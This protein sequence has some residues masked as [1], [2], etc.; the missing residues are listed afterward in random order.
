MGLHRKACEHRGGRVCTAQP[1]PA[2]VLAKGCGCNK[3]GASV[4]RL[5]GDRIEH[6]YESYS[7]KHHEVFKCKLSLY[8]ILCEQVYSILLIVIRPGMTMTDTDK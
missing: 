4:Y 8:T 7:G 3:I 1:T 2:G 5:A 6:I